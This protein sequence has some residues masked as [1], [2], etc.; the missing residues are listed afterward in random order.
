[1]SAAVAPKWT[2]DVPADQEIAY[3]V[4][5]ANRILDQAGYTRGSNG[6][7]TMPDGWDPLNLDLYFPSD[8]ATYSRV[9]QFIEEWLGEIGINVT[10]TPKSE[11]ELTPSENTGEFDLVVWAWTPY[12]DP[13]AMM[14]YLTCDQVPEEPDDGRYNDAFFCDEE[15]DRL[16]NAQR[17][18]LDEDTRVELVHDALQRFYDESPYVV[19]YKQDTIQAYR[20]DHFDGFVRQPAETGPVIY[21]QSDPSYALIEPVGS[22]TGASSGSDSSTGLIIVIVAAAIIIIGGVFFIARRRKTADERE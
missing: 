19:L 5:E 20:N 9:A 21:T 6:T 10:A 3:D 15:Y 22:F 4:N 18:E 16:F 17:V 14:S 8:D 7:R 13:T 1:M 2:L 11:P 12:S